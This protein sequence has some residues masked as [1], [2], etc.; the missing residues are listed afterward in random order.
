MHLQ[1]RGGDDT[2]GPFGTNEQ[3][4]EIR[5]GR[6]SRVPAGVHGP[7][8]GEHHVQADDDL[9][10]LAVTGGHLARTTTRQPPADRRQRHR[11]REVPACQAVLFA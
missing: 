3:L 10:D 8:V 2:E 7:P 9:L 5:P 11:L 6:G 1:P 4:G